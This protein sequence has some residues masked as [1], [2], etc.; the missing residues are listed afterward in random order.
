M[1]R[2]QS[3]PNGLTL[4]KRTEKRSSNLLFTFVVPPDKLG[5]DSSTRILVHWGKV[6]TPML[7]L[8]HL[9]DRVQTL[10]LLCFS[11]QLCMR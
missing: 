10:A 4:S 7:L 3:S 6:L 8:V 2:M 11:T 5:M 1:Q 9:V